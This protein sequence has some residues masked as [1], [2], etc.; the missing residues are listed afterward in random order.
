[1]PV[2]CACCFF[3]T[4]NKTHAYLFQSASESSYRY[5]TKKI[6]MADYLNNV[7]ISQNFKIKCDKNATVKRGTGAL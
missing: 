2:K 4:V 5:M 3:K 7:T 1:M 6:Q